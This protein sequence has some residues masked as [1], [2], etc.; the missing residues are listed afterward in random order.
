MTDQSQYVSL[1][2]INIEKNEFI[3]VDVYY[4][5]EII[6]SDYTLTSQYVTKES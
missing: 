5:A 3:S 4:Y 1:H 6:V 2:G